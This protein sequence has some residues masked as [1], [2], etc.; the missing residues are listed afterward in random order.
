MRLESR[1][2]RYVEV[3]LPAFDVGKTDNSD[4]TRRLNRLRLAIRWSNDAHEV[5]YARGDEPV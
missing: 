1:R 4:A 3:T 2:R 5:A